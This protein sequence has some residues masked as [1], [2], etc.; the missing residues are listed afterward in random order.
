MW[1]TEHHV[2]RGRKV[3]RIVELGAIHSS[4]G[5]QTDEADH[6][7]A[8][9]KLSCDHHLPDTAYAPRFQFTAN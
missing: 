9:S 8:A 2:S 4:S 7:R 3:E 1:R 5:D 6:Q